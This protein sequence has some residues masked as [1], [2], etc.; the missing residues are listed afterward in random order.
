MDFYG[1]ENLKNKAQFNVPTDNE[2]IFSV[3]HKEYSQIVDNIKNYGVKTVDKELDTTL[4]KIH[5]RLGKKGGMNAQLKAEIKK[6][7]ADSKVALG[8]KFTLKNQAEIINEAL[9][10]YVNT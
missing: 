5:Q 6:K 3:T 7:I 1:S 10:I 4:D 2:S 8:Q 9:S